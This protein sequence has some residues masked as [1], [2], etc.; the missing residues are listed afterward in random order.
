M[1]LYFKWKTHLAYAAPKPYRKLLSN[2][3]MGLTLIRKHNTCACVDRYHRTSKNQN[4]IL[5][6]LNVSYTVNCIMIFI[7]TRNTVLNCYKLYH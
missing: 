2:V 3:K 7:F 5:S 4:S 1:W 6:V